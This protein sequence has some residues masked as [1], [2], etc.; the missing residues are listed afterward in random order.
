MFIFKNRSNSKWHFGR[1]FL[2][3]K[4]V[5]LRVQAICSS[6]AGCQPHRKMACVSNNKSEKILASVH[7]AHTGQIRRANIRPLWPHN[8]LVVQSSCTSC[9]SAQ[10]T[11]VTGSKAEKTT[12]GGEL[13]Y[14]FDGKLFDQLM[15]LDK[16]TTQFCGALYVQYGQSQ[17]MLMTMVI[18]E[19]TIF[20]L[21]H[22]PKWGI[23]WASNASNS[24]EDMSW[25]IKKIY[26]VLLASNPVKR[27]I[28][29]HALY[30]Q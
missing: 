3:T 9:S 18:V 15:L 25:C 7:K 24:L 5:R 2:H 16:I 20:V 30:A 4:E 6:L 13:T 26:I 12:Y 21:N 27:T 8:R 28:V 22:K 23:T 17:I 19:K 29:C 10:L 1:Y 11:V 14:M